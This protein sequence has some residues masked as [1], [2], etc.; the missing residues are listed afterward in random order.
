MAFFR[1]DP[2]F[3]EFSARTDIGN[4]LMVLVGSV[5]LYGGFTIEPATNCNDSGECAPWLV[6][7]AGVVGLGFA[8]MGAGNLWANPR[9][10]LRLDPVTGEL[11]WWQN[12]MI[13]HPGDEHRIAPERIARIRIVSGSDSTDLHVYDTTG[14]RL[15][16][17]D[18]TVI[19]GATQRWAE[20]MVAR[21]PHIRLVVEG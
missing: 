6:P 10:G 5:F 9:R 1:S 4:W 14:E 2:L 13:R 11:V 19:P 7:I 15:P 20:H 17:L 3:C 8:A 16:F 12:R 18:E 21:W